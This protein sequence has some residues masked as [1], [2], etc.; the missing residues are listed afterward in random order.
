MAK[1]RRDLIERVDKL[2]L[3]T[4]DEAT[5]VQY[6]DTLDGLVSIQLLHK[7]F[8]PSTLVTKELLIQ[9]PFSEMY[10]YYLFAMI[11]Q[12]NME[13]DSYNNNMALFN[14]EWEKYKTHLSQFA[15][16]TVKEMTTYRDMINYIDAVRPNGLSDMVKIVYIGE[17]EGL[18][19]GK[20]GVIY[21]P[22]IEDGKVLI[23]PKA[24]HDIYIHHLFM[25]MAQLERD[26][27]TANH[28]SILYQ[29]AY[30]EYA[31]YLKK[32]E[33]L[34]SKPRQIINIPI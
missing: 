20:L 7:P 10:V 6:I 14:N 18:I 16:S 8:T 30:D 2:K 17:L 5:K 29:L 32:T 12:L 22:G 4:Y 31:K 23:I 26:Y 15:L 25:R 3:N 21:T 27:E 1:T 24:Y 19:H 34:S 13:Y 11:D 28:E 33:K 9:E